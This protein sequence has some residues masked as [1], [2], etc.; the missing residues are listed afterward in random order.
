VDFFVSFFSLVNTNFGGPPPE[1]GSMLDLST[2][3][4]FVLMALISLRR[5]FG[6]LKLLGG[7]FSLLGG[8]PKK[9]PYHEQS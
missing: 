6:R 5:V 9:A 7:W 4:W 3:F 2:L 1:K 8:G